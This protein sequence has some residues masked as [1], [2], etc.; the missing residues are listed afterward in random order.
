MISLKPRLFSGVRDVFSED[1]ILKNELV[2][3][4]K[5]VYE[6]YGFVPLETPAI[7]YV[8]VLGK[9]LPESNSPQK[10]IFSFKNPDVSGKYADNPDFWIALRYDLTTPLARVVA[11]YKELQR[12]Y[13][14]YQIGS[15]WRH[16]KHGPGRFREFIQFDFDS[17]GTSSM[18][19]D[20]EACCVMCDTLEAVGFDK[21][22][23]LIKVNNR[24]VVQ[25]F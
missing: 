5:T 14:R 22:E 24:K 6:R 25:G 20:A 10:G 21:G 23:Y 9:F 12:P 11:Q 17:V 7:E 4:I 16:E 3:Q 15:V 1:L 2:A 18:A 8:D 19:A 13:R